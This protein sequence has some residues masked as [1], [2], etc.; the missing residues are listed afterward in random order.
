MDPLR[1]QLLD[2][3]AELACA[4][5]HGQAEALALE[6][7][8]SGSPRKIRQVGAVVAP[9]AVAELCDLWQRV[10]GVTGRSLADGLV[11]ASRAVRAT[12]A[13]ERV[14][15][16][17]T[18]P[19][20]DAIRRTHQ[21]LLEVIRGARLKLWVVSYLVG[22]G[23]DAVLDALQER[24]DAGVETKLLTD[25]RVANAAQGMARITKEAPG[26]NV[27]VWPDDKRQLPGGHFAN[28]HAKCAVADARQAFVSSANLTGW[29]M[30]HNLEVGYL[31]T[32]GS[33]PKTLGR[34]LD[35]LT[36]S[37][38]IVPAPSA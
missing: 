35:E 34:Y 22:G 4:L 21:G 31:V 33:T 32:G 12:T 19:G 30:E 27:F 7:E 38:T 20:S 10:P 16:L 5:S 11:A 3:L 24:A 17:Y 13:Y 1:Q 26:C 36:E 25:H 29:A 37:G 15:L 18:G 9:K 8:S 28:L 2:K 14:E 6:L 23:S